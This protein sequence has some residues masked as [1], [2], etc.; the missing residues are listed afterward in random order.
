MRIRHLKPELLEDLRLYVSRYYI[1]EE[2]IILTDRCVESEPV[3]YSMPVPRSVH[4]PG[5]ALGSTPM[6]AAKARSTAADTA[7]LPGLDSVLV[8]LDESF[9]Q[10]LLRLIDERG[11][12][13]SVC[14]KRAGIDRK[15]FSKIRSNERYKPKK[16]TAIA[17]AMALELDI[18]ETRELLLKAGYALSHSSKFDVIV[19]YFILHQRYSI[20][21]L[22]GALYEYDQAVI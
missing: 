13:D 1:P 3:Q 17:F 22:N 20:Q 4:M 19:E 9:Q 7:A 14:Y 12:K 5:A 11:I 2:E 16:T 18:S 6:K 10:M 15:L 21:E 8:T